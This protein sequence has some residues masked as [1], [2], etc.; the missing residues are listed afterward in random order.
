MCAH[1][2]LDTTQCTSQVCIDIS[3]DNVDGP[4]YVII[5][6][7]PLFLLL[8]TTELQVPTTY[9][10]YTI[11]IQCVHTTNVQYTH[12]RDMQIC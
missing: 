7:D 6:P 2:V 4:M 3:Q 9:Y 1:A 8:I 10:M 11:H 5:L 12:L